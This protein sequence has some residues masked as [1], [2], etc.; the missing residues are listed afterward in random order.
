MKRGL[1]ALEFAA[2][3]LGVPLA[4]AWLRRPGILALALWG[5]ALIVWLA[6]RR[7]KLTAPP[8]RYRPSLLRFCILAPLLASIV[9]LADP[10]HAFDLPRHR[11]ILW[12]A[13]MVLYPAL[14]VVPQELIYRRFL[15]HR[16][17][18]LLRAPAAR[19]AASAVAFG[20]AHIIFLN[21]WAVILTLAGGLLFAQTYAR[22]GSLRTVSL[23]HALYGCL[24]FTIGLGR[25]FY[26]GVAWH[27]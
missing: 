8:P 19:I 7:A 24:V 2:L 4:I 16:Y 13:I 20:F 11:P 10:A 15:F 21:I 3:F 9:L 14:S 26:T 22:T 1:L 23:E 25:F 5:G 12:L 17:R 18:T 27:H 6:L